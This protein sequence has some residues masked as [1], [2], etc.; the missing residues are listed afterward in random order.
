MEIGTKRELLRTSAFTSVAKGS[1]DGRPH[2][3]LPIE[4]GQRN[5]DVGA[6]DSEPVTCAAD[7]KVR[8]IGTATGDE[9][10]MTTVT[11]VERRRR[12]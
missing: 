1:A 5:H 9:K 10:S 8:A 11:Y 4:Q 12:F 6:S 7:Q 2:R 3:G